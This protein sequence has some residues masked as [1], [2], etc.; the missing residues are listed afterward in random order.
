M[1]H[2]LA[3][4]TGDAAELPGVDLWPRPEAV[5][6]VF[7]SFHYELDYWRAHQLRTL[8]HNVGARA[9]GYRDGSLVET[10]KL[11]D[12]KT[13]RARIDDS[14]QRSAATAVLIGARTF[15]RKFVAYE[16][17]RSLE[18]KR[19]VVGIFVDRLPDHH[20]R[21][22]PR[23]VIPLLLRSHDIPC[24]A[25]ELDRFKRWVSLALGR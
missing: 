23:G 2:L 12:E 10:F 4:H 20:G 6:R 1:S 25:W 13:L 8:P 14:L 11:L 21:L 3:S 17:Q 9:A 16:I 18:L 22:G 5:P 7:F 15:E 19:A 24:F